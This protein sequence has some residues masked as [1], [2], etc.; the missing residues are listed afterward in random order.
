MIF[1]CSTKKK[2]DYRKRFS[3]QL[4][5]VDH[6]IKVLSNPKSVYKRCVRISNDNKECVSVCV[7]VCISLSTCVCV[8]LCVFIH[9]Y[10]TGKSFQADPSNNMHRS[11]KLH[12]FIITKNFLTFLPPSNLTHTTKNVDPIQ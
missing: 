9:T 12:R 4:K 6:T 5:L 11:N 7:C 2:S 3:R 8:C 10:N 1:T